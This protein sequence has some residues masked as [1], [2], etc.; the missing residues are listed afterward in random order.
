[1][2][3]RAHMGRRVRCWSVV[4][5]LIA[6]STSNSAPRSCHDPSG[7]TVADYANPRASRRR[8]GP[9]DAIR[10]P[11]RPRIA[12]AL[13]DGRNGLQTCLIQCIIESASESLPHHCRYVH[14]RRD[15]SPGVSAA[16]RAQ[17]IR[18][19]PLKSPKSSDQQQFS[20]PSP[21]GHRRSGAVSVIHLMK[22]AAFYLDNRDYPWT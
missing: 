19:R 10:E 7:R 16:R 12:T 13:I 22:T 6:A 4:A 21:A 11:N 8:S 20:S 5:P 15:S 3:S 1:V 2:S 18:D 9:P 17:A 14:Q